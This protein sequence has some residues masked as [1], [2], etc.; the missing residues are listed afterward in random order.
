MVKA[1]YNI[2]C[3]TLCNVSMQKR[4]RGKIKGSKKGTGEVLG[5]TTSFFVINL[6]TSIVVALSPPRCQCE[7]R[8]QCCSQALATTA[9]Q[10][11][12]QE[13][14]CVGGW[15]SLEVSHSRNSVF[16]LTEGPL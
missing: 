5:Q 6:L 13:P 3:E 1:G 7:N 15:A 4:L 2:L 12:V 14:L 11:Q 16:S 10:Q 9:M 8:N